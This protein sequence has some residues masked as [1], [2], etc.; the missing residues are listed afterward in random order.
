MEKEWTKEK[1]KVK[2]GSYIS[3]YKNRGLRLSRD[4]WR[5]VKGTE[6]NYKWAQL[7]TSRENKKIK[8]IR[9]LKDYKPNA[10]PI[11]INAGTGY[12][13]SSEAKKIWLN[14]EKDQEAQYKI[15]KIE[16]DNTIIFEI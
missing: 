1:I 14:L 10:L 5:K 11:T 16:E 3:A 9:L 8:G 13:S 15:I 2:R 12:I 4:L 7:L 6:E